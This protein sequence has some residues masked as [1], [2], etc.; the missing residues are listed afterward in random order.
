MKTVVN[1]VKSAILWVLVVGVCLSCSARETEEEG[2]DGSIVGI[3]ASFDASGQDAAPGP[4]PSRVEECNGRDDDCDGLIDEEA[5]A[6]CAGDEVCRAGGCRDHGWEIW[7][8]E[9]GTV[10]DI[11]H[12][13]VE[14]DG[15][16]GVYIAGAFGDSANFGGEFHMAMGGLDI[17]VVHLEED[18][19]LKWVRTFGSAGDDTPSAFT[20][21]PDGN[22]LIAAVY[23][24]PID[25]GGGTR[26]PE[27][28]SDVSLL[29]LSAEGAHLW[30]R[31]FDEDAGRMTIHRI[32]GS[33]E[34]L[35]LSGNFTS[36]VDFG[37]GVRDGGT[38]GDAYI[39]G[40][41]RDGSHIWDHVYGSSVAS[42]LAG[43]V[44]A[45]ADG[46]SFLTGYGFNGNDYGAGSRSGGIFLVSYDKD[47]AHQ[48]DQV[49]PQTSSGR[50]EAIMVDGEGHLL[51][52]GKYNHQID[53][54]GGVRREEDGDLFVLSL[55]ATGAYR[56]DRT[57]IGWANETHDLALGPDGSTYVAGAAALWDLGSGERSPIGNQ[58]GFVVSLDPRGVPQWDAPFFGERTTKCTSVAI[59]QRGPLYVAGYTHSG[60]SMT[61]RHGFVSA[62]L[63]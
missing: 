32:A 21:D 56:W 13:H 44:A 18:E 61:A 45:D 22:L 39:L 27:S 2:F 7:S 54:G 9:F 46:N 8:T 52:A 19:S 55:D 38:F 3:D 57:L 36:R 51:I 37:G 29:A 24:S 59:G 47:G 6:S 12:L 35:L 50:A 20:L 31:T 5:D 25:F 28:F 23:A 26:V 48:W 42:D 14:S 49:Y 60:S 41:T 17:F 15:K 1:R 4:C 11:Y 63:P 53:F 16:G 33:R 34:R 62:L 10:F 40:L 30:D 58:D 43:N